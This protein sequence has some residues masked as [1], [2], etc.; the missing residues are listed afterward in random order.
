MKLLRSDN[1]I[2]QFLINFFLLEVLG[3]AAVFVLQIV[4]R[5]FGMP[6]LYIFCHSTPH[7]KQIL[8]TI[9]LIIAVI[10]SVVSIL[11]DSRRRKE[12]DKSKDRT[13]HEDG[14]QQ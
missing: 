2:I 7:F 5:F 12:A 1:E 6:Q 13:Q 11:R 10:L 9:L 14:I 3:Q 4:F 8:F